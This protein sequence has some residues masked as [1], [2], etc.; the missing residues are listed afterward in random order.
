MPRM[1]DAEITK[2]LRH[3]SPGH[4]CAITIKLSVYEETVIFTRS[5]DVSSPAW[6]KVFD[7]IPLGIGQGISTSHAINN[8]AAIK[9][10]DTP[11]GP[12]SN[13]PD[14]GSC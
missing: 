3:I 4:A 2:P 7:A 8:A 14:D 5:T 10:D 1:N 12:S 9:F 6:Q 13:Q 11:Y